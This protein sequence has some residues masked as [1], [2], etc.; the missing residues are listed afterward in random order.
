MCKEFPPEAISTCQSL[1]NQSISGVHGTRGI[2]SKIAKD[3]EEVFNFYDTYTH[4]KRN[5]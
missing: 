3:K 2:I 4:A 5:K 1:M